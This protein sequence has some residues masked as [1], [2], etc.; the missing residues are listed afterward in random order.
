VTIKI[1]LLNSKLHILFFV[2]E[3]ISEKKIV[4]FNWIFFRLFLYHSFCTNHIYTLDN[5]KDN[6]CLYSFQFYTHR[7]LLYHNQINNHR[8]LCNTKRER[9]PMSIC[10]KVSLVIIYDKKI[11]MKFNLFLLSLFLPILF[12][13]SLFIIFF[14]FTN[15]LPNNY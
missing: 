10:I 7:T 5:G 8:G 1:Y 3:L 11:V 6:P 12:I 2:A 14:N 4:K 13:L 15:I 9:D